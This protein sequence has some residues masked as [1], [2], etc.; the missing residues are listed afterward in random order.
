MWGATLGKS[1]RKIEDLVR[2]REL[3]LLLTQ[4]IDLTPSQGDKVGEKAF[5]SLRQIQALASLTQRINARKGFRNL[6]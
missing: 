2:R 5:T 1:Q 3:L 6:D 4:R